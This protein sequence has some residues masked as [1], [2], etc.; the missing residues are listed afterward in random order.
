MGLRDLSRSHP[1]RPGRLPV[2]A[3]YTTW[4]SAQTRCTDALRKWNAAQADDRAIAYRVYCA[5]LDRE[6][7]AA[8]ELERVQ[9]LPAAA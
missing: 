2:D 8:A 7:R 5:R 1:S 4:L 3:A 9:Y 6:E